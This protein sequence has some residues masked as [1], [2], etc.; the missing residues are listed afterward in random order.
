M[1]VEILNLRP[2]PNPGKD[3]RTW[4]ATWNAFCGW[5][6]S[7]DKYETSKTLL[8]FRRCWKASRRSDTASGGSRW[9]HSTHYTVV[10]F[11]L[12]GP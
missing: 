5:Q 9:L 11:A 6:A 1:Q 3:N 7:P 12:G 8:Y 4:G 10:T 2:H